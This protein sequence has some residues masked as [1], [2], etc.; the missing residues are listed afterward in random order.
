MVELECLD[1]AWH[2]RHKGANRVPGVMYGMATAPKAARCR[3]GHEMTESNTR[4]EAR[5]NCIAR[6]CRT[7]HRERV[8][9]D[10]ARKKDATSEEAQ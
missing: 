9:R 6:V 8:L 2:D 3:N 5:K 10:R 1:C 4:L 7:C